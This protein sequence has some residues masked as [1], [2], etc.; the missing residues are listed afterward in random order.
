MSNQHR[1]RRSRISAARESHLGC[2]A[3]TV[4]TIIAACFV[5]TSLGGCSRSGTEHSLVPSA[6]AGETSHRSSS[7]EGGPI[8]VQTVVPSRADLIRKF[9]S[10]GPVRAIERAELHQRVSGYARAVLV[11]I[12][13]IVPKGKILLTLDTPDLLQDLVYKEALSRQAEAEVQLAEAGVH[14]A[15][16]ELLAWNSQVQEVDADIK[17]A[18]SD[19]RFRKRH[20]QRFAELG[21]KDAV[22]KDLVEEKRDQAAASEATYDSG[23]AKRKAIEARKATL[24]A[25]LEGAKAEQLM[26]QRK[27]EVTKADQDKARVLIE[28]TNLR[29]PFAGV[30]TRRTVDPGD[31]IPV[32]AN[33]QSEPIFVVER[34]DTV[35]AVLRVPERDAGYVRV[36]MRASMKLDALGGREAWGKVAR[37]SRSLEEKSR[38]MR[39][40]IDID[41][42]EGTIY[43]GMYGPVDLILQESKNALTIPA[44]AVYTVGNTTYVVQVRGNR[45]YRVPIEIGYDDGKVVQVAKGLR[46]D[47]EIIVSNK[48]QISEG[49]AVEPHRVER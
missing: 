48:G 33:S 39:V 47:E 25:K 30:I 42:P 17:K 22:P 36:G 5:I 1:S 40:E 38:T 11:D 46:G 3:L 15:E 49:Q 44:S 35:T 18:D 28:Y 45:A 6:K 34:I 9:N 31:F 10:A 13:D 16:A 43:P 41:N 23:L 4:G 12:G 14:A 20:A 24:I 32:G 8:S 26:R 21:A 29:A 37:F 7:E 2:S 27:V 19:R